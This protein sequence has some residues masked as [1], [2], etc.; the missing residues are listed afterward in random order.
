MSTPPQ[1]KKSSPNTHWHTDA[2][3]AIF[4]VCILE[5]N[6]VPGEA[7]LSHLLFILPLLQLYLCD[8][9]VVV[10]CVCVCVHVF[11]SYTPIPS[12]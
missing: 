3:F 6:Q 12:P 2:L 11:V 7:F 1:K 8:D 9:L 5:L 4:D 10:V